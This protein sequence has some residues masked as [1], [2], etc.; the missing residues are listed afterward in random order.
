M[1]M[2]AVKAW[3]LKPSELGLCS[4]DDDLTYIVAW[5]SASDTMLAWERQE[6]EREARVKELKRGAKN[7]PRSRA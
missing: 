6:A 7:R 5:E 4:P 2:R 1:V 3:G